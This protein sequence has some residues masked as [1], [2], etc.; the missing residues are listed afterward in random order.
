M[1]SGCFLVILRPKFSNWVGKPS[2]LCSFATS[3]VSAAIV[4]T[5]VVGIVLATS[6]A[7]LTQIVTT[8]AHLSRLC[9]GIELLFKVIKINCNGSVLMLQFLQTLWA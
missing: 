2:A 1:F 6:I 3:M 5:G 8:L 7:G 9:S 4:R